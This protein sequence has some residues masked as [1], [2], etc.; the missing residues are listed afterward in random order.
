MK[1]TRHSRPMVKKRREKWR[2]IRNLGR[3][4]I[5]NIQLNVV[6]GDSLITSATHELLLITWSRLIGN[7]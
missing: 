4:E 2:E 6:P 7:P 5:A 3:D 1:T